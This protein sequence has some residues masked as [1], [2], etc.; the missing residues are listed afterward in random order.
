MCLR[1]LPKYDGLRYYM[2]TPHTGLQALKTV[3]ACCPE[4]RRARAHRRGL[5]LAPAVEKSK[6]RWPPRAP[7]RAGELV[8]LSRWLSCALSGCGVVPVYLLNSTSNR[9]KNHEYHVP[10]FGVPTSVSVTRMSAHAEGYLP[11]ALHFWQVSN[12]WSTAPDS[13]REATTQHTPCIATTRARRA[14]GA[15][16]ARRSLLLGE[17]DH[18]HPKHR[19]W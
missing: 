2:F 18:R 9:I 17:E 16:G 15:G 10:N 3:A 13:T 11:L 6:S 14:L 5:A 19:G 1:R 8:P 7:R 4:G 12:A